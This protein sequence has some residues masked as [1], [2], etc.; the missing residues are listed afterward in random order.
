MAKKNKST[1]HRHVSRIEDSKQIHINEI[2]NGMMVTFNYRSDTV[3][4]RH[5]LVL[6]LDVN[7][8][9]LSG[10]NFNYI[11]DEIS[12]QNLFK[13]INKFTDIKLSD[14]TNVGKK[15]TSVS[16]RDRKIKGGI[17]PEVLYENVLKDGFLKRFNNYFED[18]PYRCD[19]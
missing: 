19:T 17:S 8:N 6:C 4:D 14:E 2:V 3:N 5:P 16:L 13:K 7:N 15:Y 18:H 12:I 10:I 11:Q 9:L 1:I